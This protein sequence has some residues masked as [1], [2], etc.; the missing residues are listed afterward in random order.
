MLTGAAAADS[1]AEV[2]RPSRLHPTRS[3]W[4]EITRGLR[5]EV[6]HCSRRVGWRDALWV[7]F[8]AA[9]TTVHVQR[10]GGVICHTCRVGGPDDRV[11]WGGLGGGRHCWHCRESYNVKRDSFYVVS[12]R[13]I[14]KMQTCVLGTIHCVSHTS[15]LHTCTLHTL[16]TSV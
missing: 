3:V 2:P 4:R 10:R 1:G 15:L 14:L 8:L 5:S 13:H 16:D 9:E 11:W 12:R 6:R 7:T